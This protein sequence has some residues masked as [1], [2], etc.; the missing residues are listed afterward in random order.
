MQEQ[1]QQQHELPHHHQ[2]PVSRG[3][4]GDAGDD[5]I[6]LAGSSAAGAAL[7]QEL[8][9]EMERLLHI[10][11][12]F[13]F[14]PARRSPSRQQ[15]HAPQQQPEQQQ[16]Q[17]QSGAD[18]T[19]QVWLLVQQLQQQVAGLQE[20]LAAAEQQTAKQQQAAQQTREELQARVTVLE[21]RV[22]FLEHQV[23][24]E[25]LEQPLPEP[26]R[27][28]SPMDKP[29]RS[30]RQAGRQQSY[31]AWALAAPSSPAGKLKQ[32]ALGDAL[33]QQRQQDA[34]AAGGLCDSPG[35]GPGLRHVPTFRQEQV[36]TAVPGLPGSFADMMPPQTGFAFVP[37][38]GA[39]HQGDAGTGFG[40]TSE[41]I[42]NL[43]MRYRDA[44]SLLH[45]HKKR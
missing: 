15:E 9:E 6:S 25:Q 19:S 41:L 28:S 5:D 18:T 32:L 24:P 42:S 29:L 43:S 27:A 21:G 17:Q 26:A 44:S 11:R 22:K 36:G 40:S 31:T 39:A 14:S 37:A 8:V 20:R 2:H 16:Q 13:T 1:H 33:R 3:D 45:S 35:A 34:V 7:G 12:G 30:G 4:A 10:P 38:G 23:Q